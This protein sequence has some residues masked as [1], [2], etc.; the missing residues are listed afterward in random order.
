M[1]HIID[2]PHSRSTGILPVRRHLCPFVPIRRFLFS[3]PFVTPSAFGN[4]RPSFQARNRVIPRS[5]RGVVQ[6]RVTLFRHDEARRKDVTC[7]RKSS[8]DLICCCDCLEKCNPDQHK[9]EPRPFRGRFG[10]VLGS[11]GGRFGVGFYV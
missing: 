8:Y 4:Q 10:V 1:C 3:S 2:L 7:F 6:N 9:I 5:F 11:F